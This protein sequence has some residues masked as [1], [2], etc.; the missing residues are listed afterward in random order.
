MRPAAAALLAALEDPDRG[1][2]ALVIGSYERAFFGNQFSLVA[3]LFAAAGV[4]VRTQGRWVGGRVPYRYRLVDAGPHP[5]KAD[6][7]WGR[8]AH[9]FDIDPDTGPIVEWI[10]AS[11]CDGHSVARITRA[12]NDTGTPCPSAADRDANQHRS[13]AAWIVR[14]VQEILGNPVYTGRMVWNRQRTDRILV[15]P[16][17]PALGQREVS[18]WNNPEDWVISEQPVHPALVSEADFVAVQGLRATRRDARHTYLLTALLRCALRGRAFEGHWGHEIPDFHRR[19]GHTSAKTTDRERPKN[20]H[21][22]E[23]RLTAKRPLLCRLRTAPKLATDDARATA[24]AA[25]SKP[26]TATPEEVID[27]LRIHGLELA[28]DPRTRTLEIIGK[29]AARITL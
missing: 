28:Y 8:R 15:D 27:Y 24:T 5:N 13:G 21:L 19:H 16:D 6:A 20:T 11:R 1:F 4:R 23:K 9:K 3:P 2:D 17:N 25:T 10:F 7:R 22:P 12:L 26:S 29:P 18:R 14:T